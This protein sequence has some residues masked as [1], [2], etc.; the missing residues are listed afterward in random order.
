MC[1]LL[2]PKQVH[3]TLKIEE[4]K[5]QTFIINGRIQSATSKEHG[6][7]KG[8]SLW[9]FLLFLQFTKC[10]VKICAS[11]HTSY[12]NLIN[13]SDARI[14]FSPVTQSFPTLCDPMDC[15]IPGFLV[16]HQLLEL[17][18]LMS[19]ELV[20]PSNNFIFHHSLFF[21]LSIFPSIRVFSS[22]SALHIMWPKYWSFSFS[23]SPSNEYLGPI[24]L[25]IDWFE[26]H[27]MTFI[28]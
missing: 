8:K 7:R 11:Y 12:I 5:K 17:L 14:Q 2:W 26:V 22:E 24:S 9:L 20:M 1:L 23:I 28:F 21:L 15:G 25:R 4:M 3:C 19:I 18:K 16:H 6:Y 10:T 27:A 13:I